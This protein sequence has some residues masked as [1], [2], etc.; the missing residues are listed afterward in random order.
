MNYVRTI[1]VNKNDLNQQLEQINEEHRQMTQVVPHVIAYFE[2][3]AD[4]FADAVQLI[5]QTIREKKPILISGDYDTDGMTATAITYKS[6]KDVYDNVQWFVPD[7][8]TQGYGLDVDAVREKLSELGLIITVDTGISEYDHV[9]EIQALGH[10]VIITDHHIPDADKLPPSEVIIDPKLWG[11]EDTTDYLASGALV[12]AKLMYHLKKFYQE[13]SLDPF[14][15]EMASLSI[16]SDVIE[17]DLTMKYLLMYGLSLLQVTEHPGLRAIFRLCR[18]SEEAPLTT[19]I[20]GFNI[21]PKLNAAG[22]MGQSHRGVDL[23]LTPLINDGSAE[24]QS[25]LIA[26]ELIELNQ[27][28][29]A[30]ENAIY[31]EALDQVTE[32]LRNH[33]HSLVVYKEGWHPGVLGIVAARLM[34]QFYRPTIVLTKDGEFIKGSCRS[35]DDFDIHHALKQCGDVVADFGGHAVAAGITLDPTR[36]KE[37][38]DTFEH[39]IKI[40]GLPEEKIYEYNATLTIEQCQNLSFLCSLM[41]KEPIGNKNPDWLF[42]LETCIPRFVGTSGPSAAILL[43]NEHDQVLLVKKFRPQIKYEQYIGLYVD[44]LITPIFTYFGGTTQIEWRLI[45]IKPHKEETHE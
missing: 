17:L 32:Y 43:R 36:L 10:K 7:R 11:E 44:V 28:R 21:L 20:F 29:K 6:L 19:Q 39:T 37:F 3:H 5:T 16:M 4:K 40:I 45:D 33:T 1:W 24:A 12:A 41:V 9:Q 30:V 14:T 8:L 25:L 38:Q 35:I 34:E 18:I 22:R 23:L 27:T 13:T 2:Q 15:I 42:R 26:H 31:L